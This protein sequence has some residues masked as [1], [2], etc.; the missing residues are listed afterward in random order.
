MQWRLILDPIVDAAGLV[1]LRAR[2]LNGQ[3]NGALAF[4]VA[5]LRRWCFHD[6]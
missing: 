6:L 4:T 1:G 2:I 5:F 3:D